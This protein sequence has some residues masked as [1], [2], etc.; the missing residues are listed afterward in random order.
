MLINFIY[1]SSTLKCAHAHK[2][3]GGSSTIHRIGVL[4]LL[5]FVFI[6]TFASLWYGSKGKYRPLLRVP[7]LEI[8]KESVGRATEMGR[9]LLYSTGTGEGSLAV[10]G[11]P[12]HLCGINIM[13]YVASLAAR[14]KTELLF[15]PANPDLIPLGRGVI[16]DACIAEGVPE[17]Y[18]D[19]MVRFYGMHD[20]YRNAMI[21]IMED[22]RPA[23]TFYIGTFYSEALL[24]AESG[25][26]VGAFQI[27]GVSDSSSLPFL[28]ATCDFVLIGEE[29]FVTSAYVTEDPAMIGSISAADFSKLL[30]LAV[31]TIGF[32]LYSLGMTWLKDLFI[33]GGG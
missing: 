1:R 32:L 2:K 26:H 4:L 7:G 9:P 20:S 6:V 11:G 22:E 25:N 24:I 15:V 16:K 13:S 14:T 8:I 23:S 30:I 21:G 28:I 19:D 18:R 27:A 17:F 5:S 33:L 12:Y 10:E 3:C 29:M 31:T